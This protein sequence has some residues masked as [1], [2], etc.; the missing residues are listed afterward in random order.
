[1]QESNTGDTFILKMGMATRSTAAFIPSVEMGLLYRSESERIFIHRAGFPNF[2][3][4]GNGGFDVS[5]AGG[6]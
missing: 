3:V 5:F 2:C 1:V 4:Y 6:G